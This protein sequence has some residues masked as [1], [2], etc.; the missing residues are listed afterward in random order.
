MLL[1]WLTGKVRESNQLTLVN[2]NNLESLQFKSNFLVFEEDVAKDHVQIRPEDHKSL[3]GSTP[4][5]KT[6][7]LGWYSAWLIGCHDNSAWEC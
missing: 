4:D 5:Y 7:I 6:V 2:F 1:Y 3:Y